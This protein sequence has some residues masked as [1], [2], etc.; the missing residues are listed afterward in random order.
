[1]AEPRHI[2]KAQRKPRLVINRLALIS[3]RQIERRE[4]HED[5]R[6]E[7]IRAMHA[8]EETINLLRRNHGLSMPT[9]QVDWDPVHTQDPTPA[10]TL[11]AYAGN[12]ANVRV[13]LTLDRFGDDTTADQLVRLGISHLIELAV[14][15]KVPYS[16]WATE[17]AGGMIAR[18]RAPIAQIASILHDVFLDMAIVHTSGQVWSGIR[19]KLHSIPLASAKVSFAKELGLVDTFPHGHFNDALYLPLVAL[20][21]T[22]AS[23]CEL[24]LNRIVELWS[25]FANYVSRTAKIDLGTAR[26]DIAANI[27]HH[28]NGC[29]VSLRKLSD[30][31]ERLS[32]GHY[33][34]Y[35]LT[36]G[37]SKRNKIAQI[38]RFFQ[39]SSMTFRTQKWIIYPQYTELKAAHLLL[40][41]G[42]VN[43]YPFF[44][45]G[46]E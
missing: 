25:N 43:S 10:H 29:Q 42:Y 27:R 16:V 36:R 45:G 17:E 32:E 35:F 9:F 5:L 14:D 13:A 7:V 31:I 11:N 30:E 24:D 12:T 44:I 37:A 22:G 15:D 1:M 39:C 38:S 46:V 4:R 2:R 40:H 33:C 23:P 18:I 26:A 34:F 20:A 3:G 19:Q 28:I 41:E 8:L 6:Y 21:R